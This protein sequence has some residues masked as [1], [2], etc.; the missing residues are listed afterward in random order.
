MN[1]PRFLA[2]LLALALLT[3]PGAGAADIALENNATC[4]IGPYPAATLLLPYFEVDFKSPV[5]TA[6]NTIVSVVNTSRLP[7]VVR[8]T[9]WT[10]L[11]YPVTWFNM[12]LTG[13]DTHTISL[14]EIIARG[15][16]P[17]TTAEAIPGRVSASNTA[18]PNVVPELLCKPFGGGMVSQTLLAR[19]QRTLTTGVRDDADCPVGTKHDHAVGYVTIDVINS[20]AI[21]SPLESTYWTDV[22]LYDNVLTGDYIR[23]NPDEQTGNYAGANPLV[24]IRAIPEGGVAG[25]APAVPMPFTFYDRYTPR[26]ARKMDRRQP[27]PSVWAARFI[28]GGSTGFQTNLTIWRESATGVTNAQCD[29]ARNAGMPIAKTNLVRFDEHENA[30][31][32]SADIVSPATA[33]IP[34]NSPLFPAISVSGD[35]GGWMWISLDNGAGRAQPSPYSSNRPSQSWV[36]IQMYAEGRYGV[37]FDATWLSNGCAAVPPTP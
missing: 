34:S 1:R 17:L 36:G 6:V 26:G 24:H 35:T 31:S 23:I 21:D 2:V 16:F 20:C 28:E 25:T 37:D 4:D 9:V 19:L 32:L 8:V 5:T 18:N 29:Y 13:Y 30:T 27:L 12:F 22:L 15:R 33:A 10:D 11:G 14:Y 3:A 7:Q